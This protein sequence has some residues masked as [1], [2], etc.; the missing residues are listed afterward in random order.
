MMPLLNPVRSTHAAI[1]N[2]SPLC[3]TILLS[4]LFRCCSFLVAHRQFVGS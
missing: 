4:G 3:V 2:D 1:G